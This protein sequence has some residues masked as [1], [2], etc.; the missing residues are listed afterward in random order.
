[1]AFPT[2]YNR[3]ATVTKSD[4]I[5]FDGSLTS[6]Q[7]SGPTCDAI[8]IGDDG[9]TGTLVAVL[10]GGNTVTF[11]G[12]VAGTILPIQAI[13]VNST[14]TDCASMLALYHV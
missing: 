1:M 3:A 7:T 5:N 11:V 12:L 10:Q 8:Y 14:T 2:S 13:R 9:S 6:V 4:T